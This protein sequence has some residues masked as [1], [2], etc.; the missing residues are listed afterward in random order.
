[1]IAALVLIPLIGALAV[2]LT[3][4]R[5]VERIRRIGVVSTSLTFFLSLFFVTAYKLSLGG[6]QFELDVP[7]VPDLGIHYHAGIEIGRAHV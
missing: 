3:R 1:M 4:G 5:E 6:I 7:W 2:L